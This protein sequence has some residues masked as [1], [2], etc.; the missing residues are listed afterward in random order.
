VVRDTALLADAANDAVR[1]A[2]AAPGH[3]R[4]EVVPVTGV[5]ELEAELT[6]DDRQHH[7]GLHLWVVEL[8]DTTRQ[9]TRRDTFRAIERA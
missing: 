9:A 5:V 4:E 3:G 7:G 8:P 1:L 2:D 6:G